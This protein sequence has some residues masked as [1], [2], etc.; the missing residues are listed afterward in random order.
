MRY[1]LIFFLALSLLTCQT[2]T[3]LRSPFNT[4]EVTVIWEDSISIRAL[5]VLPGSIA[6][7]GNNGVYG[8][9]TLA[10]STLRVGRQEYLG[11]YPEFRSVAHT[12]TDFF[13]LSVGTPALLF[14][15]G[16][17]GQ[18]ELV[19]SE[20][21]PEVFYDAMAFWDNRNGIAV[22]DAQGGCLSMLITRDG[23]EHWSKIPCEQLPPA[24]DGEGAF[25]A[26]NTN[27]AI[28]GN[29]CWIATSKS[30]ILYSEDMGASWVVANTPVKSEA[31]SQGIYSLVFS[32]ALT[33]FAIGGDYTKAAG[34]EFN[35][36][37]TL[38]GGLSW[39]SVASGTDPG[40]KSCVQFVPET[41]GLGLVAVGFTGISYSADGG[42]TWRS[43]SNEPFYTLRFLN[44]KEA[45]A[46]G[47]GRLARIRFN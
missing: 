5:E 12:S 4:A 3:K 40:Y 30:R 37:R 6:F 41:D 32:D 2:K 45:F 31:A 27:I 35:K 24:L 1:F 11:K 19:Y 36:A 33:G 39:E 10:D 25:A 22:G 13:M 14:K 29:R 9:Y 46:A 7:G 16:S 23:G 47:K 26:S 44:D 42:I 8:S 21:G 43:L 34:N 38:D 18:M 28:I 20:E 17:S 15:T